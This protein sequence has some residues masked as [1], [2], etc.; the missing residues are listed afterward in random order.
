M[1]EL[2]SKQNLDYM[3][4]AR[5]VAEKFV[6][7]RA[8]ELDRTG[9]YGWDILEAL[10]KYELTGI[11]IPKAY[12]GQGA[13]VLDLCL[14]VEQLA[15]ACGGV[16]VAYAVNALGSF[17][18]M[19]NATEEQKLKYL[20]S[21]ASGD[22]LIAFAL[23]EKAS[24]SDAG[25][26]RT[27][28]IKDGGD[29]VI[30]G[31]KKWNTNGGQATIYSVYALTDPSRGMRGIS[32]FI[33]ERDT[34]GFKLGKREDTM[35]IRTVS[36]HELHFNDCRVPASQLL[37]GKEG[38]G[39]KNAMMTLD[40]ARPGV[41]AQALGLAQGALEWALRYTS[42]R[43]QFGQ[44]VMSHQAIQ[45]MLADMATQVEAARQLVYTAAKVIDSGAKNVNKIAAMAKVF[46]TDTAMKVTTDAVQLFGGYGYCKDYPI[47]KYMRDAKITQIYEGTN[48]VQRLVIGRALTR[49]LKEYT[50]HLDCIVEHFAEGSEPAA[51]GE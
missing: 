50:G 28:A 8:A 36:V 12:G 15:R 19:L 16:G 26:L 27:T 4:R 41:A 40:R 31:D 33:V 5:E 42:E 2:L 10:K 23:S 35:G 46:A 45:F 30:N 32:G 49:E 18:I 6:R 14:V 48:Q 47:E 7:P 24:G 22:K 29:F 34:P 25:S 3:D 20:P 37:G 39:F 11:W 44:T 13:G 38:D 1:R 17:P 43:K 51:S 21:I 9:E